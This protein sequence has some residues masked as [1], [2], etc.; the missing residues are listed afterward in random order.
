MEDDT[1]G[2]YYIPKGTLILAN[3]WYVFTSF[4]IYH[5]IHP[6]SHHSSGKCPMTQKPTMIRTPS[7]LNGFL[8]KMGDLLSPI[9]GL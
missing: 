4:I 1:Y 5:A 8:E 3:I 6:F 9:P 7:S 2:G